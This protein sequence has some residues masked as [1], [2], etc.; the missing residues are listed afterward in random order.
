MKIQE[1]QGVYVF[2][3]QSGGQVSAVSYELLGK[4]K[5]LAGTLKT[6]VT[7]I[8]LGY[9]ISNLCGELAGY[10]ADRI[11]MVDSR[12]LE[13]YSTRPYTYCVC[14]IIKEYKPAILLFGATAIGS[15]LAPRVAARIH[16]GLAADCTKLEIADDGTGFLRMTR[17]VFGGNLMATVICAD[18][19]PQ[20]ATVRSGVM[21][22]LKPDESVSAPVDKLD[23]KIPVS[24]KDVEILK[25]VQKPPDKADIRDAKILVSGGRG[26]GCRENFRMLEELAEAFGG[27]VSSTRAC[28]DAGWV[29]KDLQ[30]GQTGKTV[31][32]N[33][34]LAFGISGS[35]QHLAGM[36]E[37]D[38]IMAVNTDESAPIFK[39]AD[40]GI[41]GDALKIIPLFTEKIKKAMAGRNR[42][43]SR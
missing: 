19:R 22:K 5:E 31:R 43:S 3:Q 35:M 8:L 16:T 40:F 36:E 14:R 26:M 2:I 10:G 41:I 18:Y 23:I 17:P 28:V 11:V 30:V 6:S 13:L 21:R 32:P 12:D 37:S 4:A 20:M 39:V 24:E 33:L 38:V 29:G 34:Y 42:A 27:A 1:Y 15:D 7:A 9:H 25:I